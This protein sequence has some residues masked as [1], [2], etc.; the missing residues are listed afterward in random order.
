M[1][2]CQRWIQRRDEEEDGPKKNGEVPQANSTTNY[3]EK[4]EKICTFNRKIFE[5]RKKYASW[6]NSAAF[7]ACQLRN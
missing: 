2:R 3:Q 4:Y 5:K 7:S 6:S 1:M